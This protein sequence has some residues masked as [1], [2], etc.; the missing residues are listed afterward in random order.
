MEK[1]GAHLCKSAK[2]LVVLQKQWNLMIISWCWLGMV[3]YVN[4]RQLITIQMWEC[5][6][7]LSFMN[8]LF[9]LAPC[10]VFSSSWTTLSYCSCVVFSR[11][12]REHLQQRRTLFL[13][14]HKYNFERGTH[15]TMGEKSYVC[16]ISFV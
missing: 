1:S 16:S 5:N 2:A 7:Y 11:S 12:M 10:V 14:K 15:V 4:S 6:L 8:F 3:G 9:S 13:Q